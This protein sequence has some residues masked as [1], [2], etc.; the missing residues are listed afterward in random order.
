MIR[1]I[2]VAA[3]ALIYMVLGILNFFEALLPVL[4]SSGLFVLKPFSL[5]GS[6]LGFYAGLTM[7]RLNEFGRKLVVLLLSIR[8]IMNVML[9]LWLPADTAGLGVEN[10]L[11]EII[12]SIE[13]PYA[14]QGFLFVWIVIGLL[15]II[16]LS[17][18]QTRELFVSEVSKDVESDIIFEQEVETQH[19]EAS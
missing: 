8:I 12:Y 13:S 10:R 14:Y 15:T 2:L 18:R 19:R 5:V 16:F 3:I 9:I 11:G 17:Q 1:K 6:A 7:F 4:S